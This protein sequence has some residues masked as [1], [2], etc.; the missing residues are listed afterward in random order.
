MIYKGYRIGRGAVTRRG[1][2]AFVA[3]R[4]TVAL[5]EDTE[6]ALRARIDARARFDTWAF[7]KF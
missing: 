2:Q 6:E 7:G 4:E 1:K 3:V 5:M